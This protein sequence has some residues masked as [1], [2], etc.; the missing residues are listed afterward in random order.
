MS[1]YRTPY[2]NHAGGNVRYSRYVWG[3]AVHIFIDE[4]LQEG[5]MNDLDGQD[6]IDSRDAAVLYDL[7]DEKYGKPWYRIFH[8]GLGRYK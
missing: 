3:G 5:M 6:R 7:I 2:Y 1:G 4:P 8:G